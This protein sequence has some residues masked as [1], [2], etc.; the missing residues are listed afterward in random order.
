LG[1]ESV[2]FIQAL[3][4]GVIIA[5]TI[6]MFDIV[7]AYAFS[8]TFQYFLRGSGGRKIDEL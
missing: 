8:N 1:R 5:D 7:D 4:S 2:T 3:F 6:N